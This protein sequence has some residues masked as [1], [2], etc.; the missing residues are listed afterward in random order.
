MGGNEPLFLEIRWV[1]RDCAQIKLPIVRLCGYSTSRA[2]LRS[3]GPVILTV[4]ARVIAGLSVENY[5]GGC[6][7]N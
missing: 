2:A 5:F 6:L 3:F 7:E 1:F 4:H